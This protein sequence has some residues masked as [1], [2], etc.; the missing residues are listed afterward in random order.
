[1]INFL[2]C[3][4]NPNIRKLFDLIRRFQLQLFYAEIENGTFSRRLLLV[5][6]LSFFSPWMSGGQAK[7]LKTCRN[8]IIRG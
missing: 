3:F 5:F 6:I 7:K 4:G 2:G 8:K 1:M